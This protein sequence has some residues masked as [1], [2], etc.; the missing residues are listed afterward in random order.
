[1][2]HRETLAAA[3]EA[4]DAAALALSEAAE[5]YAR[6]ELAVMSSRYR[7]RLVSLGNSMGRQWVQ[8]EARGPA[9][10][11]TLAH[12][13]DP[14]MG[15]PRERF[16]NAPPFLAHLLELEEETGQALVP[17][18]IRARGGL[19][20]HENPNAGRERRILHPQQEG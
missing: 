7:G 19:I 9:A 12:R 18:D 17:A 15:D 2:G 10:R 14:T 11:D 6:A 8:V 1:M 16:G 5:A 4:F 3:L 13:F 20:V